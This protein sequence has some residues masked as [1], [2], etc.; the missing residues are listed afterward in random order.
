VRSGDSRDQSE[1][2]SLLQLLSVE[3]SETGTLLPR[4]DSNAATANPFPGGSG[5]NSEEMA[6]THER[7]DAI[8]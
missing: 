4:E 8:G 3:G 5:T 7:R 2:M 1:R 6:S